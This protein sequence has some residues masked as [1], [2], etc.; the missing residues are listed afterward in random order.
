[1]SGDCSCVHHRKRKEETYMKVIRC[2]DV[3]V[4]CDFEARGQ[5]EQEVLRECTEHARSAH[6]MEEI[7]A[8]L[9]AKVKAAIRDEK[10]A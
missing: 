3:G 1:M 5:T 7:P 9:V 2:R 4:D 10:A 8:E 6:G